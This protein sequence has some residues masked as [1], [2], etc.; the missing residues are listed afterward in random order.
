MNLRR[1]W[2]ERRQ[3]MPWLTQAKAAEDLDWSV[4]LVSQHLNGI[5]PIGARACYRWAAYLEVDPYSIRPDLDALTGAEGCSPINQ[6]L[7]EQ[8]IINVEEV[9]QQFGVK[10][11][12]EEKGRI[13]AAVYRDTVEHGSVNPE[14]IRGIV[15]FVTN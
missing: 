8:V 6:K 2:N 11:T 4:G 7:L 12:P 3:E 15:R 1:L 13:T 10:M 9:I 5:T 14:L